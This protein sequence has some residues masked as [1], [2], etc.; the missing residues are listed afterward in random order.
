MA[1]LNATTGS[2]DNSD[3]FRPNASGIVRSIAVQ[4]DGKILAGGDFTTIGGLPR[5]HIARLDSTTGN[6]DGAFNPGANDI[7]Y[8]IAV[9]PDGKIL[10]GGVFMNIGGVERNHIAGWKPTAGSTDI[11]GLPDNI[12]LRY[13]TRR[14]ILIGGVFG[15][16]FGQTH[17]NIAR[18]NT[19][20]TLDTEFNASVRGFPPEGPGCCLFNRS[21]KTARFGGGFFAN[22]G[23]VPCKTSPL[24]RSTA[25]ST[26]FPQGPGRGRRGYRS[27]CRRTMNSS[28]GNSRTRRAAA[29]TSPA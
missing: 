23:V 21:E 11:V 9:Q 10:A 2:I 16:V 28:G 26:G 24:E 15:S 19:D 29:A 18:L 4:A 22:V 8:S 1:R 7:V 25:R 12:Y 6:A 5:H 13:P 3:L 27:R 20:G 17:F 14:Q